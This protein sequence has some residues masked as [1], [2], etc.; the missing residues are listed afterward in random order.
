MRPPKKL[1]EVLTVDFDEDRGSLVIA[2][3]VMSSR[4]ALE[5]GRVALPS[6][7]EPEFVHPFTPVG[8]VG[9][10]ILVVVGVGM[11]RCSMAAGRVPTTF[12]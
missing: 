10:P 12:K 1:S 9:S 6:D 3:T 2:G 7:H 4:G 8:L 11:L 5:R